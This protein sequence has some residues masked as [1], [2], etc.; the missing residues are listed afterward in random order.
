MKADR[1]YPVLA[2]VLSGVSGIL[3]ACALPSKGVGVLGWIA[4]LPLLL[5][6]RISRP[7]IAAGCGMM[8]SLACALI[9]A[10]PITEDYQFGN[11]VAAFGALGSVLAFVAGFASVGRKLS[12]ALWPIFVA[13]AGVTGELLSVYIF[14]INVAISQFQ[15]PAMLK[16]ASY[17]AIWG[18]SFLIWLVPASILVMVR[19]PR[20]AWPAFALA[21][22]AL[23]AS[24]VVRFPVERGG[25][26]LRVAAI[27][28]PDGYTAAKQ[29]RKVRGRAEVVVWPE[30]H[31]SEISKLPSTAARA[32]RVYVAAHFRER[33]PT[34]KSYNTACL[35]SPAGRLIAKQ[36]K[37]FPFG[38][39]NLTV[40]RGHESRPVKCDGFTAGMAI[41]YDTQF[42]CVIRDLANRGAEVVLVPI[43]D[44]ELANCLLNFLH[45]ATLTFRAAE[46]SVPIVAADGSG[47]S[48]IID[49][50]G[51][52]LARAGEHSIEAICATAE[53][54]SARTLASK[55]GDYFAYACA[56][57]MILACIVAL[58]GRRLG[59]PVDPPADTLK[60]SE[61]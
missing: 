1:Y 6:A 22:I 10:G 18:V 42:T 39:E 53:L 24:A 41:C 45:S 37:R 13:S 56:S 15:N 29:T 57:M 35:F 7:L 11:L 3:L 44:P 52:I 36:R 51:R 19:K 60:A 43:H 25:E 47:L 30:H 20:L 48:S 26:T 17:T 40:A 59:H 49:G 5:A 58:V 27:Q 33:L 14:P 54:R 46:N 61:N 21:V 4:F 2:L 55:G 31:L 12:P 16:L 50:S 34:G 28:A 9:L 23:V 38:K 8:C 32:N